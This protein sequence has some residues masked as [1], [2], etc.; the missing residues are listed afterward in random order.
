MCCHMNGANDETDGL[1][2]AVILSVC[3]TI[4]RWVILE[5]G[6][7]NSRG[8]AHTQ[9]TVLQLTAQHGSW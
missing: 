3:F 7:W 4:Q 1:Y 2:F 5:L 8:Q 6:L 9:H